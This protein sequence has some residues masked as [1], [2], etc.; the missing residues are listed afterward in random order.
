MY[1]PDLR[2]QKSKQITFPP[3]KTKNWTRNWNLITYRLP[4]NKSYVSFVKISKSQRC[5]LS[6]HQKSMFLKSMSHKVN[7]LKVMVSKKAFPSK[8][9]I[10]SN[11]WPKN[12]NKN[13]FLTRVLFRKLAYRCDCA[14]YLETHRSSTKE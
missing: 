4:C 9:C 5:N 8:T 12:I 6:M 13:T 2:P 10:F 7:V 14:P 1:G 11:F 3:R